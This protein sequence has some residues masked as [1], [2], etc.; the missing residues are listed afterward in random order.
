MTV[1]S[2]FNITNLIIIIKLILLYLFSSGYSNEL[3]QPFINIFI[4][5]K[6]NPWQY[7]Y[8]NNLNLDSF[9]YHGL[10]L[11]ILSVPIIIINILNIENQ[12]IINF[13]FKLPLFIAD[14]TIFLI[15]LKLFIRKKSKIIL[16]YLL[17][18]IIIYAI[19]IHSQLD[20]IPISLLFISLY[21]LIK[22]KAFYFTLFIGFALSTKLNILIVLPLLFFYLVKQYNIKQ[23][24]FY[25][26]IPFVILF[27]FDLPYMFSDGFV[28]MVLLNH[29]QSLLFDSYY[30]I[31]NLQ[32]LLPVASIIMVYLHF[33]NQNKINYDL[34]FFY[35]GILFTA[36]I[37][38]IY[39][40]PAWYVW[41]MPFMSLYFIQNQNYQKSKFLYLGFSI[42]YLVFF[43]F[44]YKSDYNDIIFLGEVI[45]FKVNNNKLINLS[46][47]LL[48]ITLLSIMY[49]FYRYGIK[50]N[51][52]YKKKVNLTIGIGG[53]SGV[54]KTTLLNS[55]DNLL[56]NK[57]LQIEGDGEHKW[58][59]GDDNWTKFT[60]LNPKAN[61]IH[62]QAEAIYELKLNNQ[63]RRSE[64]NHNTGKFTKALI[65]KPKEFIVIS[66]LHPF[67][68]P[69]LRK[70]IDL[71][72]YME[73]SE[74]LRRHWK[75]IRDIKKRGYSLEK[76][77]EQI[78]G[79]MNDARKYIYP[80]KDFSDLIINYFSTNKFILGKEDEEIKLGLKITL[81]ANIHIEDIL[82][83]LNCQFIW[84]YNDDLKT[85]F[86]RL[87]SPP[88]I[89]YKNLA[90]ETIVNIDE[91]IINDTSWKIGYEGFIQLILL[92]MISE[93]LKEV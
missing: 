55:L 18:P 37:F 79:R 90:Y 20:I 34:L 67:Y 46:F 19:Y 75:I 83:K 73:T 5:H 52:I 77:L 26:L 17:N 16:F 72:I 24:V 81:D 57:L 61:Y 35:L 62:K 78:E 88:H 87:N 85:Q 54:G 71:K 11:Y 42:I 76:I 38:F 39:P 8:N 48:E 9:P 92:I 50:S 65:V 10:M 33:F 7:Y 15:L 80:Q 25:M 68:L 51:S 82:H 59:R 53:D 31:G 56:G 91:I 40:A 63:I 86:I 2:F 4:E 36:T 22:N 1:K 60:H 49:T 64:Y 23:A 47:T 58:E 41:L 70:L 14:I 66:G 27:L 6:L 30:Q 28:K 45:N 89:N 44:F 69:K 84:D 13:I 43:I 3:F 74:E 32:L 21:F 12:I 93:K 29:K